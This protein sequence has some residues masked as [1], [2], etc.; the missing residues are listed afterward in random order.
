M[1]EQNDIL[2]LLKKILKSNRDE[3]ELVT[4]NKLHNETGI[5]KEKLLDIFH[6]GKI[7]VLPGTKPFKTTRKEWNRYLD[8]NIDIL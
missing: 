4:I 6:S 5:G 7:K 3:Y 8:Q 1:E 2:E